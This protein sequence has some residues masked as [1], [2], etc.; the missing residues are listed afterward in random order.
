M[1]MLPAPP[2]T[3]IFMANK[4]DDKIKEAAS[5]MKDSEEDSIKLLKHFL[6]DLFII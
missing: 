3:N 6:D 2:Y 5:K 4:I 1:G